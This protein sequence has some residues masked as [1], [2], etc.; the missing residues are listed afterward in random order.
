MAPTRGELLWRAGNAAVL[1]FLLVN[2]VSIVALP[3]LSRPAGALLGLAAC[4]HGALLALDVAG[5]A[6]AAADWAR[7]RSEKAPLRAPRYTWQP[8]YARTFG[9]FVVLVGATFA[10]ASLSS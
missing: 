1:F 8:W 7:R 9:A 10:Y 3:E 5:T 2:V 4:G 6:Q